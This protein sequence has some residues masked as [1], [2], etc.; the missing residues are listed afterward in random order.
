MKLLTIAVLAL[1]L[2]CGMFG[3]T[4]TP[5]PQPSLPAAVGNVF[6]S[7][8]SVAPAA[9]VLSAVAQGA[10]DWR[11]TVNGRHYNVSAAQQTTITGAVVGVALVVRYVWPR[12]RKW[13]DGGL[14]V[15]SGAFA[16]MSYAQAQK[17]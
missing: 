17:H 6:T 7:L 15:A 4:A 14:L 5:P 11:L 12:S 9:Y 16:G 2:S 3:Q 10:T 13:V 1:V 8:D